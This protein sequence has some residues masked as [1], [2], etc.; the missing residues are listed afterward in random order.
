MNLMASISGFFGL[1]QKAAVDAMTPINSPGLVGGGGWF[2]LIRE[3]FGGAFQQNITVDPQD[4]ILRFSGVWSPLTLIAADIA[5]LGVCML[6]DKTDGSVEEVDDKYAYYAVLRKPNNFQT[7]FQFAEQWILSKLFHGNTYVLKRRD[8]RG[9]VTD[10]YILDCR[11]VMP[12]VTPLGDIYYRLG[13]DYLCDLPLGITVPATEIIH[14]RWNCIW[15]PLIGISPLYSAAVSAT[16][17]R[18]I[19]RNS[20]RFFQNGS[21][22]GGILTAP[23]RISPDTAVRM[24]E[25]FERGYSG[26]NVGRTAVLGDGLA[27][28]AMGV[29]AEASQLV[30][31]LEWSV[32]DIAAT[33]H[34]PLFKV[35]G[36]I[37]PTASIEAMNLLYYSDCLQSLIEAF[38]SC[39]DEGLE[40]NAGYH[41]E[42]NV[43]NLA[44]MDTLSQITSLSESVKGGWFKPN[45]ARKKRR[46]APVAGGDTPYLQQQNFSLAALEKRDALPNPFVI[47]KPTSNPTP[48][49]EGPAPTADPGDEQAAASAKALAEMRAAYDELMHAVTMKDEFRRGLESAHVY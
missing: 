27:Y 5:K 37:P 16:M 14:D 46:L 34:M 11:R 4:D 47:D 31:Q 18:R 38:E 49:G 8:L 26:E 43:E 35:G 20:T 9:I 6:Q 40:L 42:F 13:V 23:G 7:W 30:Q 39:L 1:R 25:D 48:S 28:Q 36:P 17:G 12:L 33:V 32:R 45:E 24:K 41:T 3:S 21:R 44:R 10:L 2:N 15:H 22:P 19:Q 29:P